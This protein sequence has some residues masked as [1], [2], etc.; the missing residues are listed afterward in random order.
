MRSRSIAGFLIL[1]FF[2]T[3]SLLAV[4]FKI[5]II[6][7]VNDI[8]DYVIENDTLMAASTGGLILMPLPAGPPRVFTTGDG[9]FS[10]KFTS[11][12]RD[13]RNTLI[14]GTLD[15]L[16]GFL[17]LTTGTPRTDIS[18]KGKEIVDLLVVEDTLWVLTRDILAVYTYLPEL[19]RYQFIDFFENFGLSDIDFFAVARFKGHIWLGSNAGLFYAPSN[20]LRF[21]LKSASSW[22]RITT[23]DGL[24]SNRVQDLVAGDSVLY[25]ATAGGMVQYDFQTLKPITAGLGNRNLLHIQFKNNRIWVAEKFKIYSLK[26]NAFVLEYTSTR[27]PITNFFVEANGTFSISIIDKGI[28]FPKKN[29]QLVF[30]GPSD[31]YLG[32]IFLDRRGRLWCVSGKV[33]DDRQTGLFL[34]LSDGWRNYRFFGPG[35]WRSMSSTNS[36]MEDDNGNIWVGSW[37]GGVVIFDPELNFHFINNNNDSGRVWITSPVDDDTVSVIAPTEF[38][39]LLAGVIANPK[40]IVVTDMLLDSERGTIWILNSEAVSRNPIVRFRGTAFEPARIADRNSWQYFAQPVGGLHSD[41]LYRVARDPFNDLWIATQR[42]GVL[43][44]RIKESG[45]L[46]F[47]QIAEVDNLKSNFCRSIASDQDGYVWIGTRLGLNA[48]LNGSLYDF[49]EDYQPIGLQIEDIFVDS[50]NNKWFATN[51]GI[52]ILRAGGSPFD[53]SSWIHIVPMASDKAGENVFYANLPSETIHSIFV[54][55]TNGDVYVSTD[56]GLAIIRSNPFVGTFADL[57]RVTVGPNPFFLSDEGQERLYFYNLISGSQ[58]RILTV[59]GELVRVLDPENFQ[60]VQGGQAQWDGRNENGDPVASGI[61]VFLVTTEDGISTAGKI[62]L[63][64]K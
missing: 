46:L 41:K 14:L 9:F 55:E 29:L 20:F 4:N 40:Y 61:Y 50:R 15:G 60:E 58:I 23:A 5:D 54:D 37:G 62:L 1:I 43:Q 48:Y 57:K 2:P 28:F 64:R 19:Q 53:K 24:L 45:E 13:S 47:H 35:T 12:I 49:R 26:G 56:A 8:N 18:L 42:I 32:K 16:V 25:L 22:K 38:R 39:N 44:I 6:T 34:R 63:I 52:S 31:N 17:D 27:G 30:D 59:S 10:Q 3:L 33:D 11:I 51:E 36:I 21:N 7:D